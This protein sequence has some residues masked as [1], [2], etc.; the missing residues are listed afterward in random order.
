MRYLIVVLLLLFG[1]CNVAKKV[2]RHKESS[3]IKVHKDTTGTTE[4]SIDTSR[5]TSLRV[6]ESTDIIRSGGSIKGEGSTDLDQ[7]KISMGKG[8][9]LVVPILDSIGNMI[10]TLSTSLDPLTNSLKQL[11]NMNAAPEEY[12][13][14]KE[15][16]GQEEKK[17]ITDQKLSANVNLDNKQENKNQGTFKDVKRSP[18]WVKIGLII[19][20]VIIVL[21][22][23]FNRRKIWK[24]LKNKILKK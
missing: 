1:S 10:G 12:H 13:H 6:I 4:T 23:L 2:F 18:A 14:T 3:I 8:R 15:S 19:S 9:P 24:W 7:L 21:L 17:G 11:V 20:G 5:K 22:A 16:S